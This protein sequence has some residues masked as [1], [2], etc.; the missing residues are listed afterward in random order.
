MK[1]EFPE[2]CRFIIKEVIKDFVKIILVEDQK[3]KKI[4]SIIKGYLDSWKI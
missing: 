4:R 1:F 3:F 2:F